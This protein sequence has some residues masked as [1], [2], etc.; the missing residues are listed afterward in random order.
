VA[1][2]GRES[3]GLARQFDGALQ[4]SAVHVRSN[5]SPAKVVQRPLRKGRLGPTQAV[6]HHL[7]PKIDDGELDHLGVGYTQ[8]RLEERCHCHLGRRHP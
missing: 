5:Q 8:V 4:Q 2:C 6:E 3:T 7:H 1:A